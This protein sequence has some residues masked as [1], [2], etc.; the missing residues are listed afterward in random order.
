M[1]Y[2]KAIPY[3]FDNIKDLQFEVPEALSLQ[4]VWESSP[5]INGCE[6]FSFMYFGKVKKFGRKLNEKDAQLLFNLLTNK[7]K[8]FRKKQ[9]YVRKVKKPLT[10]GAQSNR[11]KISNPS[12]LSGVAVIPKRNLGLK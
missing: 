4:S 3:L 12:V 7:I 5:W 2:G 8:K 1:T 6:R 9:N 11:E 10:S